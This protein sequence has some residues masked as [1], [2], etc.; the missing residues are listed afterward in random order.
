M[1]LRNRYFNNLKESKTN[2]IQV[3]NS[4]TSGAE[5]RSGAARGSAAMG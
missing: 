4:I 5:L 1:E 2:L 3:L